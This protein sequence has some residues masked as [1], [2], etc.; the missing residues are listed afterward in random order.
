MVNAIGVAVRTRTDRSEI[1]AITNSESALDLRQVTEEE[2]S[3][4]GQT[5]HAS[6]DREQMRRALDCGR[7]IAVRQV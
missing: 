1:V 3:E 7:I 4:I 2:I 6:R 5:T